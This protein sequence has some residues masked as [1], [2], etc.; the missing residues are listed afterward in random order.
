[1]AISNEGFHRYLNKVQ[2][3][4]S[5]DKGILHQL[6]QGV[7]FAL[8]AWNAGLVDRTDIAQSLVAIKM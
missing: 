4:T 2:K 7:L 5:S 3:T 8:Y 6:S 1:M